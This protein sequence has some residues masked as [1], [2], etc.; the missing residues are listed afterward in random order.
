MRRQISHS[1]M[2]KN[3]LTKGEYEVEANRWYLD[4]RANNH[5]TR[6]QAEFKK[7]GAKLIRNV[8]LCDESVVSIQGK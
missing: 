8:K 4:N 1:H 5:M 7:L 6:D 3:L 2:I